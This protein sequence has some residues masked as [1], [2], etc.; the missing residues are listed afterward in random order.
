MRC[1]PRS[2]LPRS[3]NPAFQ[4]LPSTLSVRSLF[5]PAQPAVTSPTSHPHTP[6]VPR[7]SSTHHTWTW[8]VPQGGG[9]EPPL[10][11]VPATETTARIRPT[12]PWAPTRLGPVPSRWVGKGQ[13][14]MDRPDDRRTGPFAPRRFDPIRTDPDPPA[15]ERRNGGTPSTKRT[16]PH[17]E[18]PRTSPLPTSKTEER[19]EREGASPHTRRPSA[20]AFTHEEDAHGG[21]ETIADRLPRQSTENEHLVAASSCTRGRSIRGS[22]SNG[23]HPCA[24]AQRANGNTSPTNPCNEDA[25]PT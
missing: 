4:A 25:K 15:N 7:R 5:F 6:S 22:E 21:R 23:V 13:T 10:P 2:G 19:N 9:V 17:D 3:P 14:R 20:R 11:F 16:K 24:I 1:V 18:N 12:P 8:S